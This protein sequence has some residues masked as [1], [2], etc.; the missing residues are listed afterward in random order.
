MSW[1]TW[2]HSLYILLDGFPEKL[3]W[4]PNEQVCQLV[5]CKALWA[6]QRT[7]YLRYIKSYLYRFYVPLYRRTWFW[8]FLAPTTGGGRS[9]RTSSVT[10]SPFPSSPSGTRAQSRTR[11]L[12][13]P[14]PVLNPSS[15]S[16]HISVRT[17]LFVYLIHVVFSSSCNYPSLLEHCLKISFCVWLLT[18]KSLPIKQSLFPSLHSS[19][20]TSTVIV[21]DIPLSWCWHNNTR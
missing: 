9:S 11:S 12:L 3:S 14:N 21:I 20:V 4:C 1:I 8:V 5:K 17:S 13:L 10:P 7:R 18:C 16:I 15:A 19:K 2:I 6:V